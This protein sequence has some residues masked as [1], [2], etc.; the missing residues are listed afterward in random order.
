MTGETLMAYV[1]RAHC[2][3]VQAATLDEPRHADQVR[4]DVAGFRRWGTVERMTVEDAR[5]AFC[6][7]PHPLFCPC[8]RARAA[9]AAAREEAV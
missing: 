2:G 4:R 6:L 5:S 7:S 9:I 8:S 1:G 3:C